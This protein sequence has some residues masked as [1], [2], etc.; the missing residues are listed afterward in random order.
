MKDLYKLL[1]V[2]PN[3]WFDNLVEPTR[4]YVFIA[5]VII[6]TCLLAT[7]HFIPYLCIVLFIT[8]WRWAYFL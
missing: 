1:V 5:P 7:N 8:M 3:Q 2:S 4:F 6:L